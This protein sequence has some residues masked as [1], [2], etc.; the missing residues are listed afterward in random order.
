MLKKIFSL[1]SIEVKKINKI[2][3]E[4]K[5]KKKHTIQNVLQE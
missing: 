5:R 2:T 4:N 1:Y 3:M